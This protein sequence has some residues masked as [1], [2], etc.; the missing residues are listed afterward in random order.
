MQLLSRNEAMDTKIV[1]GRTY[2]VGREMEMVMVMVIVM[3]IEMGDG[4]GDEDGDG[5]TGEG[6][7][8]G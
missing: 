1:L 8:S 2:I 4:D 5:D 3:V 7:A 6:I